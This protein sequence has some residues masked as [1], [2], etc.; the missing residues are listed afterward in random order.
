MESIAPNLSAVVGTGVAA[1]LM[2]TAGGLSALSMMPACNVQA[3]TQACHPVCRPR[4][5]QKPCV[6]RRAALF[7]DPGQEEENAGWVLNPGGCASW[8]PA[9]GL[10][11]LLRAGTPPPME[12][13]LPCHAERLGSAGGSGLVQTRYLGAPQVQQTP[14]AI[15]M[16]AAKLVAGK[17]TLMARVDA[18]G[19]DLTGRAP[20]LLSLSTRASH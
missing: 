18:L 14:P 11:A 13:H 7:A 5:V 19:G 2:G 15:R 8:G 3:R 16:R 10:C 6:E 9:R 4:A 1:N 17:A 12:M 20:A